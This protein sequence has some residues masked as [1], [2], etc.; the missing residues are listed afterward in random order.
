[1]LP[2]VAVLVAS[3]LCAGCSGAPGSTGP[4]PA[5]PAAAGARP[6]ALRDLAAALDC[7]PE[8]TVDAEEL[9]EGACGAGP[10]AHRLLAFSTAQ[11]LRSWLT[12]SEN[13][14]GSYLVGDRWVVT[15]GSADSLTPLRDRL[16]GTVESGTAHDAP[17]PADPP[18]GGHAHT[19]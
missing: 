13:Y 17:H 5:A 10:D 15:A 4:A 12:E 8:I 7:T 19:P 14:G 3:L 11:G 9:T 16:G 1:V 2:G 6:P 18:P